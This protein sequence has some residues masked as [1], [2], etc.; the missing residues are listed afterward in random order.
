MKHSMACFFTVGF[1]LLL[2]SCSFNPFSTDNQLTGRAGPTIAGGAIGAGSVALLGG[3]K[4]AIGLAG[5]GGATLGYYLS[6][7]HFAAGGVDQAGG[8]VY[9]QGDYI[10]IEFPTDNIF[11]DNTAE[12]LPEAT[13]AL[14]STVEV[15]KR[16][17]NNNILVSGNT[18]GFGTTRWERTL[19]EKRAREIAAY[20]WA[21]GVNAFKGGPSEFDPYAPTRSLSYVG[22][23]DYFPISNNIK[24][25]SI[26][27]NSR[28]QITAYPSRRQLK[29]CDD[30]KVY[31]NIGGFSEPAIPSSAPVPRVGN[32]YKDEPMDANFR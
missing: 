32:G 12:I 28:I 29:L 11:E 8:Q 24:A 4:Y 10:T 9:T 6:T 23:G 18:S 21:H 2:A 3:S 13:P 14:Q 25:A 26:R 19:S 20:L 1:L 15:L 31:A 22:Y 17:P 16:Y 27:E 30:Q 7:L 5:L